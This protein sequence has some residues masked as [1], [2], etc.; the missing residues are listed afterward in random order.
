MPFSITELETAQASLGRHVRET[1]VWEWQGINKNELVGAQTEVVIKLELMQYAGS[2]KPRGA[3]CVMLEMNDEELRR[4]VTAISAGNHAIAVSYAAQV[5]GTNAKVVMPSNSP[6]YRVDLCAQMGTEVVLVD[7]VAVGFEL[8]EQ[9]EKDE[10]RK[11]VHPFDGPRTVL[12]TG[13]C[14][15]EFYRQAQHLDMAI[16]PI[17]GGG[18]AAGMSAAIKLCNPKCKIYGVEPEGANSMSLSFASGQPEK[19]HAVETVAKSLG[20]P[21]ALPYSFGICKQHI[22]QVVLVSDDEIFRAMAI[23][24]HELKLVTEPAAAATM[25][26]LLGP[27]KHETQSK[28]VGIIACGANIGRSTFAEYVERG[29]YLLKDEFQVS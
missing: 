17:G 10:G 1:P 12:G 26:A 8:V 23:M 7:D 16:L 25:A 4:G 20:A 13:T 5:L 15:L 28:R 2:F 3:L 27:L 6:K 22:E 21:F 18:L 19:I 11:F 24:F 29:E 9:I 14:G